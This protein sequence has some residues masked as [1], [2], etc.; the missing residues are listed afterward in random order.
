MIMTEGVILKGVGS[1]YEVLTDSGQILTCKA[2]GLFRRQGLVP[3]VGDRVLI[4]PQKSGYHLMQE[5]LPRKN[6]LTRPAVANIDRVFLV[7]SASRPE[8]DLILLDQ[9]IIQAKRAAIDPVPVLNKIDEADGELMERF[10]QEYRDFE[11]V[12]VS[13]VTKEGTDLLRSKME[14]RVTCFAGQSAVG[15]SSLLNSIFPELH[16]E[17]GTL[18]RKTERG[19]HTTRHASLVPFGSGAVL[20]TPGFSLFEQEPL[21]QSELDACY[22]EFTRVSFPCRYPDCMHDTEPDC[23]VKDLVENGIMSEGRYERYLAIARENFTRRKHRY[24]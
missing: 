22:P 23:A 24:D 8:P 10:R 18:S 12:F 6:L 21:E 9:L 14:G 19:K 3:T 1:F 5:I 4:D 16:L 2:R 13:A 20:D 11:T 15:K 17:V 7:I